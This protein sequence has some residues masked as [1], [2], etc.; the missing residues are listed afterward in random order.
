MVNIST[1][2]ILYNI[3]V[4]VVDLVVNLGI[5][6]KCGNNFKRV[7]REQVVNMAN[8]YCSVTRIYL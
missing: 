5:T 3:T 2:L 6:R 1:N 8:V 4:H 7:V